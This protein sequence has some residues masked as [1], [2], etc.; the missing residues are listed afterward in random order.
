MNVGVTSKSNLKASKGYL[1][2]AQKNLG[3]SNR[4]LS[5]RKLQYFLAYIR[6][7]QNMDSILVLFEWPRSGMK[8]GLEPVPLQL[9]HVAT[10][11]PIDPRGTGSSPKTLSPQTNE[12]SKWY[13]L[14]AGQI[15]LAKHQKSNI[16]NQ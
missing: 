16:R 4:I 5:W 6:R 8:I 13:D 9:E 7:G 10:N 12:D 1:T 3:I 15:V 2:L 11:R 14:C